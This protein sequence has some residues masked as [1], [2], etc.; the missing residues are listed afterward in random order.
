M[1]AKS[2]VRMVIRSSCR[3]LAATA[4]PASST[5]ARKATIGRRRSTR[6]TRTAR[7]TSTSVRTTCV[8][9]AATVPVALVCGLFASSQNSPYP[10]LVEHEIPKIPN[11]LGRHGRC[12]SGP[13]TAPAPPVPTYD[14][15]E[16]AF[17]RGRVINWY[18]EGTFLRAYEWSAI[19]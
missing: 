2:L 18:Q 4:I 17:E 5:L 12:I 16:K 14:A 11:A 8:G 10:E 13:Q 15:R 7:P 19:P 9:A 1:D 6:S 3:L